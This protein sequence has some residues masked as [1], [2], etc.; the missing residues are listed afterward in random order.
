MSQY[1]ISK[2]LNRCIID[3]RE[4]IRCYY[5]LSYNF[6]NFAISNTKEFCQ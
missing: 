1:L 3:F 2:V 4:V 5:K 6:L